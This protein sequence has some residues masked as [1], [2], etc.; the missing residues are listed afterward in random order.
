LDKNKVE[1][2][3]SSEL[4]SDKKKLSKVPIEITHPMLRLSGCFEKA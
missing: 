4:T 3:A 2:W 1:K